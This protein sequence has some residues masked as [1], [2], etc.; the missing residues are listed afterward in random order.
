MQLNLPKNSNISIS[1]IESFSDNYIWLI[2]KG[3]DA[4]LIDPGDHKPAVKVL[5]EKKLNLKAILVTHKHFDILEEYL[6]L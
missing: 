6:L 5:Q 4:I 2:E 1:P 3:N